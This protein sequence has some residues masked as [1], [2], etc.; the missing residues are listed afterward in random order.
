MVVTRS[1]LRSGPST[2]MG[3]I[4]SPAGKTLEI[5]PM[6]KAR[7]IAHMNKDHSDDMV[8]ILRHYQRLT[9]AEAAGAKMEDLDL[10]T[11]TI[12]TDGGV[13][14]VTLSPPMSTWADRRARLVEMTTAARTALGIAAAGEGDRAP[15]APGAVQFYWPEGVGILSFV[16]VTWY[17]ISAAVVYSGNMEP[18]SPF[19]RFIEAIH[20]PVGP[21]LYVWLVVSLLIPMLVIHVSEAVYM[22]KSRLA[23]RG[24]PVAS[25]MWWLWVVCAFFEGAPCWQ[26]WDRRVLEKPKAA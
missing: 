21:E 26:K 19:W 17:F 24:V 13:H 12:R 22:A 14:T 7:T 2:P 11:M 5:D 4:A 20:F 1:S 10:A 25:S 3:P 18:G 15:E 8:A 6:T 9:E 23:P 16:G